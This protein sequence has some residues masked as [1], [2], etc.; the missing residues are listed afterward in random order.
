[1][2]RRFYYVKL[3]ALVSIRDFQ[4]LESF[5][6]RK[7]P[8]GMSLSTSP[9]F[10]QI[11][12]PTSRALTDMP[13]SHSISLSQGSNPLSNISSRKVTRRK[14]PS[15]SPDATSLLESSST[16][17][18]TITPLPPPSARRTRTRRDWRAY[19]SW[20]LIRLT[21]YDGSA[22][23]VWVLAVCFF[24]LRSV[25]WLARQAPTTLIQ[26]DIQAVLSSMNR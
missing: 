25:S 3:Y 2:L 18:A 10:L 1:V 6:G 12:A 26:R 23:A 8:I 4:A 11:N 9:S 22:D 24:R 15:T 13:S 5:V 16:C 19:L 14:P 17:S 7:S 21:V 20:R